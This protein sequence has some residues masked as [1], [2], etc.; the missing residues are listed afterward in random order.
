MSKKIWTA[1]CGVDS[2]LLEIHLKLMSLSFPSYTHY[3]LFNSFTLKKTKHLHCATGALSTPPVLPV[4]KKIV[5]IFVRFPKSGP[6][7]QQIG[8]GGGSRAF[9]T[10]S[11]SKQIFYVD[12]FP[13]RSM[14][15]DPTFARF[16][17]GTL[18]KS[19]IVPMSSSRRMSSLYLFP[20]SVQRPS[21]WP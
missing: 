5:L 2:H 4:L 15:K 8:G 7:C 11:K 21:S 3:I 12:D 13:K 17:F 19:R 16:N 9:W 18:P 20:Q 10:M 1:F 6:K 14:V